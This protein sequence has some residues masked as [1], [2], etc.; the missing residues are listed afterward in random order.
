MRAAG[1][2]CLAYLCGDYDGFHDQS[3]VLHLSCVSTT[4]QE[5]A[6]IL[7]Q[8]GLAAKFT[9]CGVCGGFYGEISEARGFLGYAPL[10]HL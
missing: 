1:Y 7:H 8:L 6:R 9:F 5:P 2:V 3:G 4:C 10:Q